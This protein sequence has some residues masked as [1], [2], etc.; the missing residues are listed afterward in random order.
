M[1]CATL[2]PVMP[3]NSKLDI[4]HNLS[5]FQSLYLFLPCFLSYRHPLPARALS[6]GC[7]PLSH[8]LYGKVIHATDAWSA[9]HDSSPRRKETQSAW[10]DLACRDS[11]AVLFDTPSHWNHCRLRTAQKSH[12]A[13]WSEAFPIAIVRN[14]LSPDELRIATALHTDAK[15]FENTE[16]RCGQF[17]DRLGLYGLSSLLHKE[18]KPLPQTF[19]HQLHPQT[20][21]DPHWSHLCLGARWLDEG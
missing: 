1:H 8:C 20:V 14:L 7:F 16:C 6:T 21:I 4:V 18:R 17:V 13:A 5:T 15:I 2:S 11:L 12:T 19:N 3:I 9:L 10:D